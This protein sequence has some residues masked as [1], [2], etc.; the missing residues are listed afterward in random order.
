MTKIRIIIADDHPIVLTGLGMLIQSDEDLELT[1]QAVSGPEARDMIRDCRPD[2]AILDISLPGIDGIQVIRELSRECPTTG[3]VALT[4]HE[5]RAHFNQAM[6]AGARGYVLKRSTAIHL[7]GAIRGVYAGGLYVDPAMTAYLFRPTERRSERSAAVAALT[8]RE[9]AVMRLVAT[10]LTIKQIAGRLDISQSS[11]ET[12]KAR[13]SR[14]LS[15]TSRAEIVRYASAQGW[16][17]A[18]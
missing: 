6:D 15:V 16:L 7:L 8:D 10:G 2:L 18:I 5:D 1:G 13:A 14:K 17:T 9:E 12:Y 3:F 11:I 4:Q